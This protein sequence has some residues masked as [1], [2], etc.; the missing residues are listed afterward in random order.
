MAG[1]IESGRKRIFNRIRFEVLYLTIQA[2]ISLLG[3]SFLGGRRLKGLL[4]FLVG[5]IPGGVL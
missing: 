3:V 2:K 1:K 5:L 4:P